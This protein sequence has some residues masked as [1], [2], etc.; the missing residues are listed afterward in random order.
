MLTYD[1]ASDEWRM[2]DTPYVG[3]GHGYDGNAIHPGTGQHY[4]ALFQ[5]TKV[6]TWNGAVWSELPALPWPTQPAVGLTWFSALGAA[7]SLVF[8]NGNGRAASFDGTAWTEIHGAENAPWGDYNVFVEE[9]PKKNIAWL[10]AGNGAD[11]VH[12][13][14]GADGKLTRL[15]DA[16]FSLN[17][18]EALHA[19]DT[20]TGNYVVADRNANRW[21]NFDAVTDTWTEITG[22]NGAPDFG[23]DQV[24]S[25]DSVVQVAIPECGVILFLSHYYEH[26]NVYLYRN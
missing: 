11:K 18:A 8:V 9:S 13:R 6:K 16:A 22:M 12:Y 10:G 19:L 5:D 24:W 7:G 2:T 14:L 23:N 25:R 20:A 3:G 26:R 17:L 15:K 1:V 4:F 21:W